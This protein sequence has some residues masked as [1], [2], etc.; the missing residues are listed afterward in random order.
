MTRNHAMVIRNALIEL[1]RAVTT[2]ERLMQSDRPEEGVLYRVHNRM[3]QE[4]RTAVLRLL[5]ELREDI[6]HLSS[7]L[8]LAPEVTD[9]SNHAASLLSLLWSHLEDIRPRK[10]SAYGPVPPGAEADLLEASVEQMIIRVLDIARIL[11]KVTDLQS[12]GCRE[13]RHG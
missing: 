2:I 10:L 6:L 4:K 11:V 1:D 9:A 12:P 13:D 5:A 7:R 8:G 3:P